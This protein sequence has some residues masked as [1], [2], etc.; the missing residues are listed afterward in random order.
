MAKVPRTR[1]AGVIAGRTL[2]SGGNKGFAKEVAAYLL[3]ERRVNGLDSI[4]RDVMDDWSKAGYL[5]VLA[6]S[7]HPLT[8]ELKRDIT[9]RIQAVSPQAKKIV[10]TEQLDPSVVGGVR[11]RLANRQLDLSVEHKLNRFKQL[12]GAGK[13]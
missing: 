12:T 2:K 13:D 3:A 10:I 7:A 11:L 9:A 8:V 4:M 1:I 5:E 6:Y